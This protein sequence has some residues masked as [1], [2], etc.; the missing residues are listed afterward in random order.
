MKRRNDDATIDDI[1]SS[2]QLIASE[3][4]E[5]SNLKK[6]SM[7]LMVKFTEELLLKLVKDKENMTSAQLIEH[8]KE[9][10]S[11]ELLKFLLK[12]LEKSATP[13]KFKTFVTSYV[14]AES[15]VLSMLMN[16]LEYF[17]YEIIQ[18]AN[19][20]AYVEG[21]CVINP[22]HIYQAIKFDDDLLKSFGTFTSLQEKKYSVN[23]YELIC[24]GHPEALFNE[25]QLN[26]SRIDEKDEK[27][28]YQPL[29]YC[30]ILG[31]YDCAKALIAMGADVF[32]KDLQG[33]CPMNHVKEDEVRKQLINHANEVETND[34]SF[35]RQ[36]KLN[37]YVQGLQM[38]GGGDD[39]VEVTIEY[40]A[41]S[42]ISLVEER[43]VELWDA[44]RRKDTIAALLSI[45]SG[46]GVNVIRYP[47][48]SNSDTDLVVGH[49]DDFELKQVAH[50][51]RYS[52]EALGFVLPNKM[53]GFVTALMF[54]AQNSD[55]EMIK[56]LVGQGAL[57]ND[58]QPATTYADGYSY[59]ANTPLMCARTSLE[60]TKLLVELGADVN[61]INIG[62]PGYEDIPCPCHTALLLAGNDE[63][64]RYLV[65]SGADV[66]YCACKNSGCQGQDS[67]LACYWLSVVASGDTA[68]AAE[69]ISK[70]NAD[71]NWPS[72]VSN[73]NPKSLGFSHAS[74]FHGLGQTVLMV[75]IQ[76]QNTDMVQLLLDNNAD[77]NLSEFVLLKDQIED[78]FE[79]Y[80][81]EIE[82]ATPLAVAVGCLQRKSGNQHQPSSLGSEAAPYS[83]PTTYL[84]DP[85]VKALLL[86]GAKAHSK[87]S[88]VPLTPPSG[89]P[90]WRMKYS[91]IRDDGPTE[92]TA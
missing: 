64:A 51:H 89:R 77:P 6:E 85:I 82:K 39:A 83:V 91:D 26:P 52:D 90:S 72:C 69:L 24:L 74:S 60:T 5:V 14:V 34:F 59:G 13:T 55:L 30:C 58:A 35:K 42:D 16:A 76:Q 11:D 41:A 61:A 54:A 1:A 66:N 27:H 75:A 22:T 20:I 50:D 4:N 46:A 18:S 37:N 71:V 31:Y 23:L 21:G 12:E 88:A 48:S 56:V 92:D 47:S 29:H 67:S 86:A 17:C 15:N 36:R 62:L 53:K 40:L 3:I 49:V 8:I 63:V 78:D 7:S 65:R 73:R 10:V 25:I 2:I 9:F 33:L 84:D 68:W 43:C 79:S 32:G 19:N 87:N 80:E 45:R 57:V 28:G 38:D 70:Y 81:E 44:I